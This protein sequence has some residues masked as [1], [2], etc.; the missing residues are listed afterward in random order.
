MPTLP[1]LAQVGAPQ[2][3]CDSQE[4]ELGACSLVLV[5]AGEGG[6]LAVWCADGHHPGSGAGASAGAGAGAGAGVVGA[7]GAGRGRGGRFG[8]PIG[9][10]ADAAKELGDVCGCDVRG[11]GGGGA[12][13]VTAGRDGVVRLWGL[14]QTGLELIWR[15]DTAAEAAGGLTWVS[16][17]PAGGGSG[18]RMAAASAAGEVMVLQEIGRQGAVI[19]RCCFYARAAC[20]HR[21]KPSALSPKPWAPN[22]T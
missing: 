10:A 20:I 2:A 17:A 16:F 11:G 14:C 12:Y 9:I 19:A 3:S 13:V 15:L 1:W 7:A 5:A 22:P 6:S 21:P 18:L 4:L 8:E